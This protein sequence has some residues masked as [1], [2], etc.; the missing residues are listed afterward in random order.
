MRS[1][2]SGTYLRP[3]KSNIG[4]R[5]GNADRSTRR[6]SVQ[7]V[8]RRTAV[9]HYRKVLRFILKLR[10]GSKAANLLRKTGEIQLRILKSIRPDTL[11][12]RLKLDFLTFKNFILIGKI[13]S[14][15]E[16]L[17]RWRKLNSNGIPRYVQEL[18]D[19]WRSLSYFERVLVVSLL[20]AY[21]LLIIPTNLDFSTII[22]DSTPQVKEDISK[23]RKEITDSWRELGIPSVSKVLGTSTVKASDY[24]LQPNAMLG[25]QWIVSGP[26]GKGLKAILG[27]IIT[28]LSN[29]T[30][31]TLSDKICDW[32][33]GSPWFTGILDDE[34][35]DFSVKKPVNL[36]TRETIRSRLVHFADRN[37]TKSDS[38]FS[39]KGYPAI[40][41]IAT[42]AEGG[43]KIR[44]IAIGNW[45]LQG[46]LKPLHDLVMRVV[47]VIPGDCTYDQDKVFRWYKEIV[48]KGNTQFNSIDLSAATDR[49]PL[50]V[51]GEV[52]KNLLN[53]SEV[54][55]TWI[56]LISRLKYWSPD[57]GKK[58]TYS[59][60][61][62]MG[63]YT[64]WAL[65]ALTNHVL[66]RLAFLRVG[67]RDFRY[68]V[69]GDDVVIASDKASSEYRSLLAQLG[70]K[71]SLP[72]RVTP[73]DQ[74]GME[75]AS[76][77]I[78]KEGNLRPLP[79]GLLIEGRMVSKL[80]LI[81]HVVGRWITSEDTT[82]SLAFET[83]F[84]A[85]FGPRLGEK[86]MRVWGHH[87]VL[88][89]YLKTKMDDF[90]IGVLYKPWTAGK[91]SGHL[92]ETLTTLG[93][94][95]NL[96]LCLSLLDSV[97]ELNHSRGIKVM[98]SLMKV[99]DRSIPTS[100]ATVIGSQEGKTPLTSEEVNYL[101]EFL[102]SPLRLVQTGF[103]VEEDLKSI[104]DDLTSPPEPTETNH[105]RW[106]V[107]DQVLSKEG[108][109][110]MSDLTR[111]GW[112]PLQLFISPK[113]GD[114]TGMPVGRRA[115]KT[116]RAVSM[117]VKFT[118]RFLKRLGI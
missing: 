75:F 36:I 50:G 113:T 77:L 72:K 25:T 73:S 84:T 105:Q 15:K 83:L 18:I 98:N 33:T 81:D 46:V 20:R 70:V 7:P 65:L 52:L 91:Q 111:M 6:P 108:I 80:Q 92:F 23:I 62:G 79:L 35:T 106:S 74:V 54:A 5:R 96:S 29:H 93:E 95:I 101:S 112:A 88:R 24:Y 55:S 41:R 3:S 51:Q 40:G 63:L 39:K 1:V 28:F 17:T 8:W 69:L 59:V 43:G 100:V 64:S 32:Y 86:F 57:L 110:V 44:Y 87:Y 76:K 14:Q 58:I 38:S 49:L 45:I 53:S 31:L 2:I 118:L 16:S 42:F 48:E 115:S 104:V 116:T 22:E 30:I 37:F 109:V 56:E 67:E 61:Q 68:L 71:V 90:K 21:K 4:T 13:V 12:E 117:K 78:R 102:L 27:D 114:F 107:G 11:I 94:S 47:R 60:G 26:Y 85:T 9:E 99:D 103:I 10:E 82:R 97:R 66:V 34:V 19:H 89:S